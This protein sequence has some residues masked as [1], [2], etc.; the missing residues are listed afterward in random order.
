MVTGGLEVTRE[1]LTAEVAA[2]SLAWGII[3]LRA[4]QADDASLREQLLKRQSEDGG[5]ENSPY[6]TAS[7]L[8]ALQEPAPP[9]LFGG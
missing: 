7:A 3:A 9:F 2:S 8:L 5:W 1:L 6:S 4:W